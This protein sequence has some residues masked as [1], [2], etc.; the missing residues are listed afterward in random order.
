MQNMHKWKNIYLCKFNRH[1]F[2]KVLKF[3][4]IK[5][6]YKCI[7]WLIGMFNK[8][9]WTNWNNFQNCIN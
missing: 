6:L 8:T 2:E 1:K 7:K 5:Q 3:K 4:F 9:E